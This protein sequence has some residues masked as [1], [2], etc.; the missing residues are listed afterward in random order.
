MKF[1]IRGVPISL[2]AL[3]FAGSAKKEIGTPHSIHLI[4]Q[5]INDT[6]WLI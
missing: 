5:G 1:V 3:H 2:F 6:F 4:T